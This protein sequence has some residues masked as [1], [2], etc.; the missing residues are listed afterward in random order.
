MYVMEKLP[1]PYVLVTCSL[2]KPRGAK[3]FYLEIYLFGNNINALIIVATY[4]S[5]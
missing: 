3:H 4:W 5:A 1:T 2:Y